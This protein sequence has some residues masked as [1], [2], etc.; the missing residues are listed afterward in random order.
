MFM[1]EI[2]P[3]LGQESMISARGNGDEETRL[4]A[5]RVG[6]TVAYFRVSGRPLKVEGESE[7]RAVAKLDVNAF[8]EAAH[9][10]REGFKTI[11][12]NIASL[13]DE[14]KPGEFE[15]ELSFGFEAKGKAAIVPVLLTGESTATV[16]LKVTARWKK[17]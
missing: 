11:S 6:D 16:G 9:I 12:S 13:K 8:D 17:S 4:V 2:H 14:L 7:L 10:V 1:S 15:V 3:T 5:Q